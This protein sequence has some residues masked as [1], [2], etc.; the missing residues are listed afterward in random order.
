MDE[1]T[2][3]LIEYEAVFLHVIFVKLDSCKFP[4]KTRWLVVEDFVT[5][6]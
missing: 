2:R 5:T 4:L 1:E 6:L 3:V